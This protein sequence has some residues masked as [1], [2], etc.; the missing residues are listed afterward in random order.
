MVLFFAKYSL[1]YIYEVRLGLIRLSR[2]S[3]S[4]F[5]HLIPSQLQSGS[6]SDRPSKLTSGELCQG[7]VPPAPR[8]VRAVHPPA[9]TRPDSRSRSRVGPEREQNTA[10]SSMKQPQAARLRVYA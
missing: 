3:D 5:N 9:R 10:Y 4:S 6:A 2:T 7:Q 1:S 8:S